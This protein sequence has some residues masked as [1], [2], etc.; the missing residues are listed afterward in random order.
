M[1]CTGIDPNSRA[2][3]CSCSYPNSHPRASSCPNSRAC[4]RAYPAARSGTH[5]GAMPAQCLVPDRHN[6]LRLP[7]WRGTRLDLGNR[8]LYRR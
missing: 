2:C 4:A 5:S 1:L 8:H 6:Q 7:I 3:S